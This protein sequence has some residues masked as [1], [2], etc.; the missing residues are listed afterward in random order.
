VVFLQHARRASRLPIR[1]RCITTTTLR[2][3]RGRRCIR[4]TSLERLLLLLLLLPLS[5]SLLE[6]AL[7][8]TA[9]APVTTTATEKVQLWQQPFF[10]RLNP[11]SLLFFRSLLTRLQII[12]KEIIRKRHR[13]RDANPP[14]QP[15]QNISRKPRL[16]EPLQ[17]VSTV[18]EQIIRTLHAR[19]IHLRVFQ[20]P[21]PSRRRRRQRSL[22]GVGR[23]RSVRRALKHQPFQLGPFAGDG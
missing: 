13:A 22:P 14:H 1:H 11:S 6:R 23:R 5:S 16:H 17:R 12:F 8:S 2:K 15:G 4:N 10:L 19:V 18:S 20:R 3:R 7:D 9:V 21:L